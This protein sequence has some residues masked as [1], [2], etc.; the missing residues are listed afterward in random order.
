MN[1]DYQ[2][3]QRSISAV[4]VPEWGP[5]ECTYFGEA[6]FTGDPIE[7]LEDLFRT[8]NI[9]HPEGFL[10]HS[11]SVGDRIVLGE[12]TFECKSLGWEAVEHPTLAPETVCR[13]FF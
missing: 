7:V 4:T 9:A 8:F 5:Y 2:I 13:Y 10:S 3:W 1:I 12:V 11:L 6:P